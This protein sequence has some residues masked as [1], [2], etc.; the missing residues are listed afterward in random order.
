MVRRMDM[1]EGNV[2]EEGI[3]RII[4]VVFDEARCKIAILFGEGCKIH[5]LLQNSGFVE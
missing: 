5:G 3:G 1:R 4:L 2:Q